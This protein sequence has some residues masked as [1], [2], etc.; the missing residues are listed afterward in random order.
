MSAR[1]LNHVELLYR[2]GER[3]LALRLF[4]VLGCEPV[5]RG[6][7]WFTALVDPH[8][9]R[10]FVNNTLYASE[11]PAAQ[12][13]F[14]QS[15]LQAAGPERDA[16]VEGLRVAPQY[17]T[18]FGIHVA[19]EAEFEDTL[20]RI[21]AAGAS[22]EQLAG[23]IALDGVYRP[24]EPGAIAPNMVQAFAWTDVVAA[25]LLC[26]GQHIEIQWQLPVA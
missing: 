4:E 21:R 19:D 1:R 11:V 23:R 8:G 2:P 24:G 6:S 25:G 5:D 20:D 22:D 14:E 13:A 15:V 18:H 10:D 12:W 7:H 17:S 26:L 3:E 9:E 16:Y